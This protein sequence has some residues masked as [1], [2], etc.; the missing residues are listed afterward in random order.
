[1]P[2]RVIYIA[3]HAKTGLPA[4]ADR[5][6]VRDFHDYFD[7]VLT[8]VGKGIAQGQS[9][10]AISATPSLPGFED[11]QSVPGLDLESVLGVAYDELTSKS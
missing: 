9:R 4:T 5:A 7:A 1:M 11:Y 10:E 3:G 6:A 2:A 8:L